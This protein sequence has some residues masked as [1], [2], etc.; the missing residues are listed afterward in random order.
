[1]TMAGQHSE[2]EWIWHNG[3]LIPWASATIHIMSHVVHYGSSVFEG[4]RC[5]QTPAGPA[6]FRLAE[7]LRRLQDSARI[8]RMDGEYSEAELAA[9]CRALI[10]RNGLDE[11][12]I[13]PILLRGLGARGLNPVAS[14][15]EC[16]IIC[17]P[18]GAYLGDG[19]LERG[20]DVC[21]SSWQRPAPNTHPS[22]AKAG[23]NYLN[24][25]L[26][27][28]EAVAN[29]YHEGV[30]VSPGGLISEGSG[31]NIFLFRKGKLITPELDGTLLEGI[32]RDS[33]IE[34]ARDLGMTVL[35]QR[36]PRELLYTADEVFFT[37]TAAEITPV[38][39]VDKVVIGTG[40]PGSVTR[41]LQERLL[42][43]AQGRLPDQFGW[44]TPV[45][46]SRREVAAA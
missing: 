25:Q 30:A 15:V 40:L 35:E 36:V 23:G 17:W 1:M 39:S 14:P 44:L 8:Y 12:Y 10:V 43:I 16:Y 20:V 9:A 31:Q 45:R 42:G 3:E 41:A 26:I 22:L 5:Y 2:T 24:S 18:W 32:T 19:A 13:R 21:V 37:G 34:I 38:R 27:T 33:V 11:C 29:G 4:I 46:E 28:L 7:H 6:I